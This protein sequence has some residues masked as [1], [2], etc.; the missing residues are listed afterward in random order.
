MGLVAGKALVQIG[1]ND[2]F[3]PFFSPDLR[4]GFTKDLLSRFVMGEAICFIHSLV[5]IVSV[6]EG[7]KLFGGIHNKLIFAQHFQQG[8]PLANI[9]DDTLVSENTPIIR[10]PHS[11][12]EHTIHLCSIFLAKFNFKIFHRTVFFYLL[13]EPGSVGGINIYVLGFQFY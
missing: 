4:H 7:H 6:D 11:R 9:A 8:L 10:L 2:S 3:E 12:S 1:L 5:G 13:L